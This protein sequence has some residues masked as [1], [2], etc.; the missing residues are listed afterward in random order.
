M[1]HLPLDVDALW[2]VSPPNHPFPQSPHHD[3][4]P[5]AKDQDHKG[6]RPRFSLDVP[7]LLHGA[8]NFCNP[9]ID[10]RI[11]SCR[12]EGP[13]PRLN[14]LG[15]RAPRSSPP[16]LPGRSLFPRFALQKPE[17]FSA[18][19]APK[20]KT[21]MATDQRRTSLAGSKLTPAELA[22]AHEKAMAAELTLSSLIR[23]LLEGFEPPRPRTLLEPGLAAQLARLGNN[24][25]QLTRLAHEGR[26]PDSVSLRARLDEIHQHLNTVATALA[27][28]AR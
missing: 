2:K 19:R 8:A 16:G 21:R 22:R 10:P 13:V 5:R 23:G 6:Y 17:L 14:L 15:F 12:E 26:L 1:P 27:R 24:L 7:N 4:G 11:L 18:L 3:L 9:G 20:S 25:N 28:L